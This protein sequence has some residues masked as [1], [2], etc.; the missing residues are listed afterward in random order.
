MTDD[1][2]IYPPMPRDNKTIHDKNRLK[3]LVERLNKEHAEKDNIQAQRSNAETPS[4][5][6]PK[7]DSQRIRL[8]S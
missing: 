1:A 5:R 8:T 6:N 7:G 3:H 2:Y 4:S